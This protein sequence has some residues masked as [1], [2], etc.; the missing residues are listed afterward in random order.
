M[1][2]NYHNTLTEV[3]DNVG[4]YL[5]KGHS[6]GT[7]S[8]EKMKEHRAANCFGRQAIIGSIL[9]D[10]LPDMEISLFI[11][12]SHGQPFEGRDGR[13]ARWLGHAG[14]ILTID[15]QR[16]LLDTPPPLTTVA[17]PALRKLSEL[18]ETADEHVI[19]LPGHNVSR[20]SDCPPADLQRLFG[21]QH[22]SSLNHR[23]NVYPFEQGLVEY[24][25][26]TASP[27]NFTPQDYRDFYQKTVV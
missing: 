7:F 17:H 9:S 11:T 14:S 13:Q 25:S 24:Q 5:Y 6:R 10:S 12:Q 20:F 16:Y 18:S 15:G 1:R 23:F 19:E 22:I 21:P 2:K 27:T 3:L 4:T 8:P 26:N